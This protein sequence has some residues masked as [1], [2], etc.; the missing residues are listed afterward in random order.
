MDALL[1]P[2]LRSGRSS[3]FTRAKI[4]RLSGSKS[5]ASRLSMARPGSADTGSGGIITG[6]GS[7]ATGATRLGAT[8]PEKPRYLSELLFWHQRSRSPR[9]R[10]ARLSPFPIGL[11]NFF[12]HLPFDGVEF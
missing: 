6:S 2:L 12:R 5:W 3:S 8:Q 4:H 1:P 11:R 7:G 9:F 10:G